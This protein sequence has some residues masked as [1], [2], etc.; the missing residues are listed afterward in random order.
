VTHLGGAA[1]QIEHAGD[2]LI[3]D[4]PV[5]DGDFVS[6]VT[7][8]DLGRLEGVR[9]A[10]ADGRHPRVVAGP[11]VLAWLGKQGSI[12][13]LEAPLVVE[14]VRVSSEPYEPIPW[15]TPRE[16]ARKV[17]AALLNPLAAGERVARRLSRP[18]GQPRVYELA[19]P[20]G[21]RLVHLGCA[22]HKGVDPAWITAAQERYGGADWMI[23]GVDF[24]EEDAVLEHL[25]GFNPGVL[26]LTDL[27]N[28]ERAAVGLPTR[29]L[30]PTVDKLIDRGVNAYPF[31]GGATY[32]F[33]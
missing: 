3:F 13:A 30:T 32:R 29:L 15:A 17:R 21:A 22:L 24:E 7:W 11:E 14:G 19:F 8:Q 2:T 6:L 16:A 26:L 28:A 25:P 9:R 4:P 31:A 20:D 10:V 27:L 5:Q 23:V 18:T 33:S 12:Q 1:I